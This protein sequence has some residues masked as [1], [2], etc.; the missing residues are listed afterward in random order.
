[1]DEKNAMALVE[2]NC[3]LAHLCIKMGDWAE[4]KA[5][6]NK[7]EDLLEGK[8]DITVLMPQVYQVLKG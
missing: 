5:Y 8:E 4:G 6:L 1:M 7:A 2:A 3:G